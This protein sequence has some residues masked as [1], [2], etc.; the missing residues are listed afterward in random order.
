MSKILQKTL[1]ILLLSIIFISY[2]SNIIRAAYEITEA[3]IVQI[4]EAPY[5]LK[6][7]KEDKGIYTYCTCSI[8]GHYEGNKF[9][10]SYCLNRDLHGV[11]A[12]ESYTV[13]VD[14][15]I[16]NPQVWRAVKNGYPYKTALEMGLSSDFNAFAVTKFAIYCLTGQAD[17]NLYIADEEDTEGQAMIRALH[18]LVDIGRNGT[19]TFSDELKVIKTSELEEDGNYYSIKYKVKSGSTISKYKI[20]SI[21]G[22]SEGDIVT[23]EKGNIKTEFS[24]GEG[25]KV[26]I[27]KSNLDS[28]KNINIEVEA[29]LKNYPMFYGKT[30]ISG[31]QDYLLTANSYQNITSKINT[32]LKLNTGRVV[33]NKY[34]NETKQG[35]KDT[36]FELY[37]SKKE[38]IKTDT[39]DEKGRIEFSE[40]YQGKYTLKEAKSNKDYVLDE[41][42]EFTI[43]VNYNQT[44]TIDIENKHKKGDLIVYKVDKENNN[45]SLGNVGFELYN[46]E[47][48]KLIG[49][50]Y[51]DA[52]GK[53]EIKDLRTGNYKLK[54]ISTNEWYNLAEDTKLQI[55]W[56][57]TTEKK[58]ENELKKGQI[59]VIKVDKDNNEIKIPNVTFNILDTKG[60]VLEKITTNEQGE[61]F[62]K[63][64][65]T[66]DYQ[67]IRLQEIETN[68][69]YNINNEIKE[70]TL[71]NNQ[72]KTVI[73]ENE[74]KKGQ[75]KITKE[76]FD[77]E[78]VK[79]SGVKFNILDK[80]G[81]IVDTLITDEKGQA[82]SKMLPI[83]QEYTIQE[84]ETKDNYILSDE[85]KTA[86][87]SENQISEIILKN[88]KK[89]GQIKVVKVDSENNEIK[90]Q[91]VEFD[92]LNNEG[93]VLD[94]LITDEN[95]EAISKRLP[96]DEQ[97]F[98]KETKT[99]EKY[100][101]SEEAKSIILTE[102]QIIKMIIKNEKIKGN[103]QI[104]KTT[105]ESSELSGIEKGHPLEGV[106]FEIYD[107]SG[108]LVDKII[109]NSDGTAKSKE[110]EK[111]KYKVKEVETNKWYILDEN[112]Y[113]VEIKENKQVATLNLSNKPV[114]PDEE[115]EKTGPDSANVDEEIEYKVKVKNTGNVVLNNFIWE[116]EL[117]T[118]YIRVTKLKLGT[119]NQEN[120]YKVYYKTNF[121]RDYIL[122][123]E[124]ISTNESEEIDFSKELSDNE[125][126]TNIKIDFGT[127]DIGFESEEETCIYGIINSDVKSQ[128]IFENKVTLTSEYNGY[129]LTK[130]SKWKTIVYKILPL[131]GM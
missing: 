115:I 29:N 47:T 48:E 59:K 45:I 97:Y 119:Y 14:S 13:D 57:E 94:T 22:L 35:I 78:E 112:Y 24:S 73:F 52:N 60:N 34:D 75:I 91:N 64:Y 123:F 43:N 15:L 30:R 72:T 122:L 31:T 84:I 118:D 120:K 40:L 7:Y 81:Q 44:T 18:K 4:G 96:I 131:T 77:N 10:P 19:E 21:S 95:G 79:L 55:K 100:I 86:N 108:N 67:K 66:R 121:S 103:I 54:E 74:K 25:F 104:I 117:P 124:D 98:L 70:I 39:T 71:E 105:S 80:D 101:L 28:N 42:S 63:Q 3:Y 76:D 12:V 9:Y 109:T 106:K 50:Y 125:Y 93:K 11:G 2:V 8:V 65:A 69:Y 88:E 33:I 85:T 130:N 37:N 113:T 49:T 107:F 68:E 6:Y 17:I 129:K 46:D 87:I 23:D 102:N 128:D 41:N 82:I 126:I 58:I 1:I 114:T 38:L 92:I 89:K 56:N 27:L 83:D 51:T 53:I 20:K 26:K 62:T 36:I 5:H 90:L 116:D 127:V 32:N 61:A 16:E 110:L 111:G 99:N